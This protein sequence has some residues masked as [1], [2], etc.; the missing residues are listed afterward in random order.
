[1]RRIL[2]EEVFAFEALLDRFGIED[3]S[4]IMEEVE[5]IIDD[6]SLEE[7]FDVAQTPYALVSVDLLD[8]TL[9]HLW[10]SPKGFLDLVLKQNKS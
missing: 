1:M 3:A 6:M 4:Q 5:N 9:L 7:G 8:K 10:A 2:Q